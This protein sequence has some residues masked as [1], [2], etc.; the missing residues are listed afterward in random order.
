MKKGK[1]IFIIIL[2]IL[3]IAIVVVLFIY[4]NKDNKLINHIFNHQ[5]HVE[6]EQTINDNYNGVYKYKEELDQTYNIFAGCSITSLDKYI[7]V[8][9]SDYYVYDSTC[10][11]TFFNESGK[12]EDLNIKEDYNSKKYYIEYDGYTYT[13]DS[14]SQE[15]INVNRSAKKI[16]LN[17]NFNSF[18][19]LMK[20]TQRPGA[21]YRI[22][23]TIANLDDG[24]HFYAEPVV[25]GYFNL[26]F[27]NKA[28]EVVYRKY[29]V[30]LDVLPKFSTYTTNSII[31]LEK[32][33]YPNKYSNRL[34]IVS[35][36]GTI[37]DSNLLFP[38]TIQ[39]V[40]LNTN[41]SIF[42]K[43]DS[44]KA[45]YRVLIGYDDKFCR[46]DDE[47]EDIVNYEFTISYDHANRT[48]TKLEF[49][50]IGLAKDGCDHVNSI[51]EESKW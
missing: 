13:S 26:S 27:K 8:V 49:V 29:G 22:A 46:L 18:N 32:D 12:T 28:G 4:L 48:F 14:T 37:Y 30:G 3:I 15:F 40:E 16:S 20:N 41:N 23:T 35:D 10:M 50:Q 34:L 38:V 45:K 47:S 24:Y 5:E 1:K 9:N 7:I 44:K 33:R 17:F 21:N 39:N 11:G 2:L 51:L 25:D 6:E 42:I 36:N 31:I 43:Y 19:V